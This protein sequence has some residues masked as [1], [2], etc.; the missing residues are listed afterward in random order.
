MDKPAVREVKY[1][2]EH[3]HVL[4]PKTPFVDIILQSIK[5]SPA[6]F[7]KIIELA[8]GYPND[9]RLVEMVRLGGDASAKVPYLME[10]GETPETILSTLR[11]IARPHIERLN[12]L[13]EPVRAT[14][15]LLLSINSVP[16]GCE[17]YGIPA[18]L[19]I[20]RMQGEMVRTLRSMM[21]GRKLA[22]D[23]VQDNVT[24]L[25]M[26]DKAWPELRKK[27]PGTWPYNK[28]LPGTAQMQFEPSFHHNQFVYLHEWCVIVDT[29]HTAELGYFTPSVLK[30]P[31]PEHVPVPITGSADWLIRE[32]GKVGRQFTRALLDIIRA[33]LDAEKIA[34]IA[35]NSEEIRI[36]AQEALREF[37][38]KTP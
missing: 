6:E 15:E 2:P 18:L 24:A 29:P 14:I 30:R 19:E 25:Q 27:K 13:P 36:H 32:V 33:R 20:D 5:I 4:A 8:E 21:V 28:D 34:L 7:S 31:L 37:I 17:V 10:T 16:R 26:L 11:E 35:R 9:Q 3:F 22:A 1:H 12:S 23:F 38:E